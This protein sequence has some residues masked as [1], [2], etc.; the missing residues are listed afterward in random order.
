METLLRQILADL[1]P[2]DS[3]EI[4]RAHRIAHLH[5]QERRLDAWESALLDSFGRSSLADAERVAQRPLAHDVDYQIINQIADWNTARDQGRPPPSCVRKRR[6]PPVFE[7]MAGWLRAHAAPTLTIKGLWDT[8]AEPKDATQ[9]ERAFTALVAHR[10]PT[11]QD[12]ALWLM[13]RNQDMFDVDKQ[14]QITHRQSPQD[15]RS[16][17]LQQLPRYPAPSDA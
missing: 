1:D 10:F 16:T 3:I 13:E 12:L 14:I 8:Q 7:L 9:W 11:S 6:E 17:S 15:D 5:L 2:R 4:G